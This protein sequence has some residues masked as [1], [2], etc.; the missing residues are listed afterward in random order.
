LRYNA[1]VKRPSEELPRSSR[2]RQVEAL[3]LV[4]IVLIII[5]SLLA[6][7]ARHAGWSWR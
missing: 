1:R 5:L 7:F 3:G 2:A 6:R 4:L